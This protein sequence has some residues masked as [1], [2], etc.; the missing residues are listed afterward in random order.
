[1]QQTFLFSLLEFHEDSP[2][3]RFGD[4]KPKY[5]DDWSYRGLKAL[6]HQPPHGAF[7]LLLGH[8]AFLPVRWASLVGG[9][10]KTQ[11]VPAGFTLNT[12]KTIEH[13]SKFFFECIEVSHEN[14]LAYDYPWMV[15]C[16]MIK[17][18][19]N[20]IVNYPE[21]SIYLSISAITFIFYKRNKVGI[22]TV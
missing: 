16:E 10:F 22:W 18:V 8:P 11:W 20:I 6:D 5:G 13:D 12:A 7:L 2:L 1:M 3:E 21:I 15:F 9:S 14:R 17:N 4:Y 19:I